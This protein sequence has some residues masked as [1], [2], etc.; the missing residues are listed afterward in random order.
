MKRQDAF[1]YQSVL[2]TVGILSL[3]SLCG[4]ALFSSYNNYQKRKYYDS[5]S[6]NIR[7][8]EQKIIIIKKELAVLKNQASISDNNKNTNFNNQ[9]YHMEL[10]EESLLNEIDFEKRVN[11]ET[12]RLEKLSSIKKTVFPQRFFSSFF[13]KI[14][15]SKNKD[16]NLKIKQKQ[17]VLI[18]NILE[19]IIL[20]P[21]SKI[22]ELEF[23]NIIINSPLENGISS[24]GTL[25]LMIS[26]REDYFQKL[27]NS[28]I[29][30]KYFFV[31]SSMKISNSNPLPPLHQKL[32]SKD[33]LVPI[34]GS[35]IVTASL[36]IDLFDISTISP[37]SSQETSQNSNS[38]S[39]NKIA[40]KYQQ[41]APPLF[42]ARHYATKNGALIDPIEDPKTFSPPIPN[43][44][45]INNNLDYNN[46]NIAFEDSDQTG[47]NN[48]EKW[49]ADRPEEEPGKF[50][51]DPNDPTSHPLL[52][53]KLKCYK[54]DIQ[55]ESYDIYFL[56][57]L[58]NNNE[59]IFEIQ[60][61]TPLPF[62]NRH[63][64][65]IVN[66]KI[67]DVKMGEII[68]GIPYKVVHY[69]QNK[70]LYKNTTYDSSELT[71]EEIHTK[72]QFVLIKKTA[73]HPQATQIINITSLQL[74]NTLFHPPHIIK[75]KLGDC[76][77]LDYFLPNNGLIDQKNVIDTEKYQLID[78]SSKELTIEKDNHQYHLHININ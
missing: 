21:K 56:G 50:F 18:K 36:K 43:E 45:L 32:Y 46:P 35:E 29:E 33:H 11:N 53:T 54:K 59:N 44:W 73:C 61:N 27:F 55:T 37:L 41:G 5:L 10:E 28:I 39:Q 65:T 15:F 74:E 34:L 47:F 3:I 19:K 51:T 68:E 60:P 1:F 57:L 16:E 6:N 9:F 23:Q 77:S 4:A 42:V 64:F 76:F 71:I 8:I 75:L 52:W 66:K 17:F 31:I 63:G 30:N 48:L 69:F 49:L 70:T 26:M 38:S 67:R 13:L 62:K 25:S 40:W 72:K 7:S 22:E 58:D 12:E 20:F 14:F 78:C 24:L 2:M